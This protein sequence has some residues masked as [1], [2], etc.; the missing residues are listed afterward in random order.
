MS[1]IPP[2]N[3]DGGLP[4]Q[5]GH[6][7]EDQEATQSAD[8]LTREYIGLDGK[9]FVVVRFRPKFA[10]LLPIDQEASVYS[11]LSNQLREMADQLLFLQ[12]E[13]I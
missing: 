12:D 13:E 1:S 8:S 10:V 11:H 7:V 4:L 5:H 3:N 6:K 2:D 9:S